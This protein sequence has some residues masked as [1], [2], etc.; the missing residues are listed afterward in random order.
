MNEQTS[1]QGW[2]Q[3]Q[4]HIESFFSQTLTNDVQRIEY[5]PRFVALLEMTSEHHQNDLQETSM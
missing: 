4:V 2:Q 3:L 5:K 1:D